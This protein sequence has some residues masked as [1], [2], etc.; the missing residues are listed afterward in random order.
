MTPSAEINLGGKRRK[1]RSITTPELR[2]KSIN[3]LNDHQYKNKSKTRKEKKKEKRKKEKETHKNLPEKLQ[4]A[5]CV[6]FILRIELRESQP[7][8]P[9]TVRAFKQ[10]NM[11]IS[12]YNKQ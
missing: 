10:A 2:Y 6:F 9:Q 8:L 7:S 5:Y 11:I 1:M 3:Q 4:I 12:R